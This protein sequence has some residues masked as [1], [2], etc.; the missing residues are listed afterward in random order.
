[1]AVPNVRE[2]VV[3]RYGFGQP[4]TCDSG[5]IL[6]DQKRAGLVPEI[7]FLQVQAVIIDRPPCLPKSFSECTVQR[8]EL[9]DHFH[10]LVV[11]ADPGSTADTRQL[12]GQEPQ[13]DALA[14]L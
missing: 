3:S 1:N 10:A 5:E 7:E 2:L 14:G 6:G 4:S 13:L 11:E 8:A 9:F 12:D